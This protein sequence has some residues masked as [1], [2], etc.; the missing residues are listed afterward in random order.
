MLNL[1]RSF[2]LQVVFYSLSRIHKKKMY[3]SLKDDIYPFIDKHWDI[4]FI[5]PSIYI[6]IYIYNLSL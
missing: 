4:L 1:C 2:V 6:Y 5:K 3:F